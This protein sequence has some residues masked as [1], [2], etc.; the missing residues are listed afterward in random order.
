MMGYFCH[1]RV[2]DDAVQ[3][4]RRTGYER[5][6]IS[7]KRT[8]GG[9][10][11]HQGLLATGNWR[12]SVTIAFDVQMLN[13]DKPAR[14]WPPFFKLY[15]ELSNVHGSSD[16]V[17]SV[18]EIDEVEDRSFAVPTKA[19]D[20]PFYAKSKSQTS[21]G[22][23]NDEDISNLA[24]PISEF[25]PVFEMYHEWNHEFQGRNIAAS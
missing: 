17:K 25:R 4:R 19:L 13:A 1:C 7:F 2:R 24:G 21:V 3:V 6:N 22:V 9:S 20:N 23:N 10:D 15:E 12:K 5:V 18:N 14:V 11:N 16:K 8:V